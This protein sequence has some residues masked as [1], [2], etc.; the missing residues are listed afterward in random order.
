MVKT[1]RNTSSISTP[2][3][4]VKKKPTD[5][6]KK[7]K[8][9]ASK[10]IPN[11][12]EMPIPKG[13]KEYRLVLPLT[14]LNGT[15]AKHQGPRLCSPEG[16]KLYFPQQTR[17]LLSVWTHNA[18]L[19]PSNYSAC[20]TG[21]TNKNVAHSLTFK[22]VRSK[23]SSTISTFASKLA[24]ASNAASNAAVTPFDMMAKKAVS[25]SIVVDKINP[26]PFPNKNLQDI[27]AE[28]EIEWDAWDISKESL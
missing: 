16:V 10:T 23:V 17:L 18:N 12:K 14:G 11:K 8:K 9:R 19:L 21:Y 28:F 20:V 6:S 27:G 25:P 5:S 2:R 3:R 4:S 22:I 24:A 26:N 7:K 15:M 1:H 13:Y